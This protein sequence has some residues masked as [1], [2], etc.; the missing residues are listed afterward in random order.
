M[1]SDPSGNDNAGL[2][3]THEAAAYLRVSYDW[4]KKQAAK[5]EVPHTRIGRAVR[6]SQAH[7]DQIVRAGEQG[8]DPS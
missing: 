1:A 4:L 6:F 7:L 2:Y 3:T 8:A 5:R